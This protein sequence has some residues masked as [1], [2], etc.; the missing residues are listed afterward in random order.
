MKKS[1]ISIIIVVAIAI[2]LGITDVGMLSDLETPG[3]GHP[4]S[5]TSGPLTITQYEH[6]IT[7]NIFFIIDGLDINEKGNIKIFMPDGRLWKTIP[8]DGSEKQSFNV[9]FKPDVSKPRQICEQE[10]LVGLWAVLFDNNAYP[11]L[12]FEIINEHLDGPDV[13]LP[14]SC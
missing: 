2:V 9:Y 5:L 11:P 7:A 13:R 10:E 3:L 4:D 14:K 12:V 1:T 6:K 8:Y